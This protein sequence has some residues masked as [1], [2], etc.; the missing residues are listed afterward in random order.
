MPTFGV[1]LDQFHRDLME[2][3]TPRERDDDDAA[4]PVPID[5]RT[6]AGR[7]L[8]A[9]RDALLA[10][11]PGVDERDPLRLRE[12]VLVASALLRLERR[13]LRGD[14][15]SIHTFSKLSTRLGQLRREL[16]ASGGVV[17][18]NKRERATC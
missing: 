11:Y 6:R 12:A 17:N 10:E 4:A 15:E 7:F 3:D 14:R 16:A 18:D 2:R 1:D 9:T 8:T 5:G 13:V